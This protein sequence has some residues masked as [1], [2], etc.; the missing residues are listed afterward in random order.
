LNFGG[1]EGVLGAVGA[2]RKKGKKKNKFNL[3]YF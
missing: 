1:C 3:L 2:T